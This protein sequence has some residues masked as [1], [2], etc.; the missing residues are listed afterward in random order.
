M[1]NA[2]LMENRKQLDQIRRL[3]IGTRRHPKSD[4]WKTGRVVAR[5][6]AAAAATAAA[7]A[8]TTRPD[9]AKSLALA[10]TGVGARIPGSVLLAQIGVSP[11]SAAKRTGIQRFLHPTRSPPRGAVRGGCFG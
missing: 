8:T 1:G 2:I 4:A 10:Q 9:A 5:E 3:F 11:L 7:G 6:Q